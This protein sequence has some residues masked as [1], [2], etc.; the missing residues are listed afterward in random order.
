MAPN[1]LLTGESWQTISLHVKGFDLFTESSYHEAVGVLQ[2]AL[3]DQG[4]TTTHMPCHVAETEF[5]ATTDEITTHDT[6][7]LSDIGYN[8]LAIPPSTF[9]DFERV[10]DRL[11]LVEDYVR[12]GGG[13]LMIGGYLSFQGINGKGGYYGTPIEEALPVSLERFDDRGE[14]SDGVRAEVVDSDHPVTADLP[15]EWPSFLGYNRVTVDGNATELVSV[16]DDPLVVVGEHGDGR[17][18]V[19]TSDCAPHWGPPEFTE[20]EHYGRMWATLI[21]WLADA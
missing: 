7:V 15:A 21:E 1:T 18:A 19:F 16:G 5:P 12:G 11:Q 10:P 20:W 2:E 4:V 14:R 3:E 8:T 9:A 17:V 6:V 13:L